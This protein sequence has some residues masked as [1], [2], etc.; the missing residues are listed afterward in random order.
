M[1]VNVLSQTETPA[2]PAIARE[3]GTLISRLHRSLRRRVRATMPDPTLPQ[4]YVEV[5][6][7]LQEQPGRRVQ[8]AAAALHLAPNS[9]STI[10]QQLVR[11]GYVVREVDEQDRR[12]ARLSLTDAA[13]KRIGRWRDGRQAALAGALAA[14][15]ALDREVIQEA[16]PTL[17]RLADALEDPSP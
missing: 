11:L 1:D 2:E 4:S 9:A 15:G 17:A 3:L 10:V 12:V 14:L 13:H 5:L 6:R 7:L 8:D 16:M